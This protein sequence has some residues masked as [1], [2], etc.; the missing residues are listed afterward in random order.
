MTHLQTDKPL[1]SF[2]D[3]YTQTVKLFAEAWQIDVPMACQK[4][5]IDELEKWYKDG[6]TPYVTFRENYHP[7]Y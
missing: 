2:E 1:L 3:W 5:N 4:L 7:L 6:F